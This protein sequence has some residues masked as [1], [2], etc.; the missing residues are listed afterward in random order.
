MLCT[1]WNLSD[2]QHLNEEKTWLNTVKKSL[3]FQRHV[4]HDSPFVSRHANLLDDVQTLS[5]SSA[6]IILTMKVRTTHTTA[7]LTN[8]LQNILDTLSHW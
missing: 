8:V 1:V 5:D 7:P 3:Q 6:N 2:R 4:L